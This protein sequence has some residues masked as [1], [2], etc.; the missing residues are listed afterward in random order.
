MS[1]I[2]FY[3]LHWSYLYLKKA[4]LQEGFRMK[5]YDRLRGSVHLLCTNW[6]LCAAGGRN[7]ELKLKHRNPKARKGAD[8]RLSDFARI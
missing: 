1:C 3:V 5:Y 6:G 7:C 2:Y 8:K 4:E